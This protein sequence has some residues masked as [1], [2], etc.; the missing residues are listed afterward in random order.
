M[1][2]WLVSCDIDS[3]I[4]DMNKIISYTG[5]VELYVNHAINILEIIEGPLLLTRLVSNDKGN[6]S[7]S[8]VFV[9]RDEDD[10]GSAKSNDVDSVSD[11][12]FAIE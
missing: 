10:L 1:L 3:A 12:V 9:H 7:D 4:K 8:D 11:D 6:S 5:N 2:N